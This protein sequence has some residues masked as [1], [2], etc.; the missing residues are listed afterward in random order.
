[1]CK[2]KKYK[3]GQVRVCVGSLRVLPTT[4]HPLFSPSL[5]SH[6]KGFAVLYV[7]LYQLASLFSPR[8]RLQSD[9]T[10]VS[11]LAPGCMRAYVWCVCV[12]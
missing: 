8:A 11:Q 10:I 2:K 3:G 1:M 12:V 6:A 7:S 4:L 5:P 9:T